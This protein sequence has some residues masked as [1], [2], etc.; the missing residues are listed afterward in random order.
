MK[1]EEAQ[2]LLDELYGMKD[3]RRGLEKTYAW[4]VS[5]VGELSET[6]AKKMGRDAMAE[7]AADVLAWLLSFCNVASINLQE[8]F[9]AKYSNG[10][11]RCGSKPCSCLE[12]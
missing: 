10:C 9:L 7:E 11:P 3:R 12:V 8:A 2:N 6:I 5:E 1:V 4:L